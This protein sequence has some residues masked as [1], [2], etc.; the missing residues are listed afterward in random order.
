MEKSER[1]RILIVTFLQ[2]FIGLLDLLGVIAFGLLGSLAVRGIQS[3]PPGDKVL[4]VLTFLG[5][6]ASSIQRQVFVIG[7]LASIILISR[8]IITMVIS[9]KILFYL[10][11][12]AAI[13]S[14][15]L[16]SNVLSWD[17]INLQKYSTQEIVFFLTSGV[18]SITLGII[19]NCSSIV[20]DGSILLI[21]SIG[22]FVLDPISAFATFA[23][24]AT[25]AGTIYALVNKRAHNLGAKSAE[26]TMLSSEKIIEVL[27]S[28]REASI[29]NR[30][31]Y[32]AQLIGESR[33]NLANIAAELTFIPSITKYL[34]EITLVIGAVLISALEFTFKDASHAVAT[35]AVFLAASSRIAP[36]VLRLQN[37][38]L[39]IR[40]NMGIAES[41]L[42]VIEEN[43]DNFG[44]IEQPKEISFD[45]QQVKPDIEFQMVSFRYP[46]RKVDAVSEINLR[47]PAGRF[48]AIVGPSGAGKTTLA[49]ILLGL[50]TPQK[51]FVKIAG[52]DVKDLISKFPGSIS[53]VPQDIK[54]IR[55]TIR[56]NITVGFPIKSSTDKLVM[57]AIDTAKLTD[58]VLNL[59]AGIDSQVGER[60]TKLS[61]GQRQRLGISRAVFTKPR[62]IVLDEATSALDGQTELDVTTAIQNLKGSAT[63]VMIAHRLATVRNA[64][65]VIYM[66]SGKIIDIGTFEEVRKRVPDFDQQAQLM[67]L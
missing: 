56:D 40:S 42:K 38:A 48:V 24:F 22:L 66:D 52:I 5:L 18:Q 28:Y 41:T 34:I 20:S 4:A 9:R 51:G 50:L 7:T 53:Y 36:A 6:Q 44:S 15:R 63:V 17:L 59:P 11:R 13:L 58:L 46:N 65:L 62:L 55:G 8:S 49:D 37:G 31:G 54:I 30:K 43:A 61:G 33:I 60:G 47:I 35:L 12:R 19:A 25:V 10:S 27:E 16:T 67:G 64:D 45:Y 32:Y 26:L 21:L 14:S 57:E 3:Q 1:R 39:T 29:R 2:V 23:L